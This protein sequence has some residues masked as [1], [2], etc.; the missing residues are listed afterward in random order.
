[1]KPPREP[2]P[3]ANV[4]D[5]R[6]EWGSGILLHESRWFVSAPRDP[7]MKEDRGAARGGVG[8]EGAAR[9]FSRGDSFMDSM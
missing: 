3:S 7:P 6:S 5:V 2:A 1:M 4:T 8:V 9:W